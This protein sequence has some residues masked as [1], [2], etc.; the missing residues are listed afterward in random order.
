M[1][2]DENDKVDIEKL[3]DILGQKNIC[4]ILVEGGATLSGSFVA[5]N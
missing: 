3:L 4:S 2:K 1:D 5:K